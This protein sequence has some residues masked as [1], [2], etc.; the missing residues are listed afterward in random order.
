MG[1]RSRMRKRGNK[2]FRR[3]SEFEGKFVYITRFLELVLMRS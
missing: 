1:A 3:N 2:A